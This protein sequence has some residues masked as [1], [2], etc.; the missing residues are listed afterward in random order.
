MQKKDFIVESTDIYG[1]CRKQIKRL[2]PNG[3]AERSDWL[4]VYFVF[5][6]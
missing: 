5:V 4:E 3:T 6:A 2:A 1:H